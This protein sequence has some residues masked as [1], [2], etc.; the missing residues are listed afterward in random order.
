MCLHAQFI[1]IYIYMYVNV[2][3]LGFP[4]GASGKEPACQRRRC[5]RFG[6]DPW[7]GKM[8]GGWHGNPLQYSCLENPMDKGAW[9]ATVCWVSK[10]Q[11]LTHDIIACMHPL[12]N[13]YMCIFVC[14]YIYIVC[15]CVCL[16][17]YIFHSLSQFLLFSESITHFKTWI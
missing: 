16:C 6:F 10:S 5:K 2:Y 1:Y 14:V 8:P 7:V 13:I 3:I 4:G 9:Q 11:T 12:C 15:V 17:V